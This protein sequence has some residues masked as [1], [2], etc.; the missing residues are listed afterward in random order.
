VGIRKSKTTARGSSRGDVSKIDLHGIRKLVRVKIRKSALRPRNDVRGVW[1]D[2]GCDALRL[3]ENNL[4]ESVKR[5][6]VMWHRQMHNLNK[7]LADHI[8]RVGGVA[9]GRLSI[10]APFDNCLGRKKKRQ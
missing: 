8:R 4:S 6:R 1:P 3:W 7:K 10:S 5:E 9:V 2:S